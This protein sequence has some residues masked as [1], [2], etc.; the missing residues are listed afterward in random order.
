MPD[1]LETVKG[2]LSSASAKRINFHLGFMHVDAVGLA[3]VRNLITVGI[4]HVKVVPM[5]KDNVAAVY[6]NWANT[7]KFPRADYG[8]TIKEKSDIL[9]ECVH[10]LHDIYGSGYYHARGGSMFMTRS[11]NEATAYVADAL[12]YLYETGKTQSDTDPIFVKA[13]AIAKRIKDMRGAYV[14]TT[15][16][17]D[18]RKAIVADPTYTYDL[19]ELTTANG[20]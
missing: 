14:S 18:L 3:A 4:V 1:I 17:L 13:A 12:Y 20:A 8:A 10:A 7:L 19:G 9:H 11:E 15:E 5:N 6:N 2:V 16:A